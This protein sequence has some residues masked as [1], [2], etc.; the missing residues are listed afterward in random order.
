LKL[1][2]HDEVACLKQ[3]QKDA[4]RLELDTKRNL[5]AWAMPLDEEEDMD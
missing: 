1:N 4:K 5:T 3:Q 2:S